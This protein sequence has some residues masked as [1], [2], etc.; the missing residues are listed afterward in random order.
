MAMELPP[1]VATNSANLSHQM[2]T[3]G[4]LWQLPIFVLGVGLLLGVW[5]TRPW[6]YDPEALQLERDLEHARA[7]LSQPNAPA[8]EITLILA[9]ALARGD[10]FPERVGEIHFLL[11]SAYV[12]LAEGLPV[13]QA[14]DLW[15]LARAQ[16]EEAE[17]LV[18]P[19]EDRSVL[20]YRL[21]K[22][23]FYTGVDRQRLIPYVTASIEALPEYRWEA[24]SLL[25]QLYLRPPTDL[26]AALKANERQLQLPIEDDKLLGPVRLLRGELLLRLPDREAARKVLARISSRAAPAVYAQARFLLARSLQEDEAWGEA[27]KLWEELLADN[28]HPIPQ[29]GRVLYC[30]GLCY[31][32][33]DQ[34]R[35]R[36]KAVP[37]LEQASATGGEEGQAAQILL[38]QLFREAGRNTDALARYDRALALVL[39]PAQY[40]NALIGLAPLQAALKLDCEEVHKAGDHETSYRLGKLYVRIAPPFAGHS[41][42]AQMAEARARA[43]LA[44]ADRMINPQAAASQQQGARDQFQEAARAYMTAAGQSANAAEQ[45][46]ALFHAAETLAEAQDHAQAVTVLGQLLSLNP[47]ADKLNEIWYR[48]GE[49]HARLGDDTTAEGYFEKSFSTPGRFKQLAGLHWALL[50]KRK[51]EKHQEG[52]GQGSLERAEQILEQTLQG[53]KPEDGQVYEKALFEMADLLYLRAKWSE[54]ART[55][56]Q[57]LKLHPGSVHALAARFRLAQC[58]QR[59]ADVEFEIQKSRSKIWTDMNSLAVYHK[60]H[61]MNL[62]QAAAHYE[63]V[64]DDLLARRAM[65]PLPPVEAAMLVKALFN[66]A[67][68][69]FDLG[70]YDEAVQIYNRLATDY[71]K[72]VEGLKALQELYRCHM[73]SSPPNLEGA[74]A[75]VSRAR[76]MMETMGDDAF[77][78][79]PNQSREAFERYLKDAEVDLE[80]LRLT[81]KKP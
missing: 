79:F 41:L 1:T 9:D 27:A 2:V 29:P 15:R 64:I 43:T 5:L 31:R 30:L 80:K 47:S 32:R 19:D 76:E 53:L 34:P 73:I 75:S 18:V 28:R 66:K 65:K 10:R 35:V 81:T 67:A 22:A 45:A 26:Q 17:G 70:Q 42:F 20:I 33:S 25:T 8:N 69:R 46:E 21:G 24:L 74:Y 71:Q 49:A 52:V 14:H 57:A 16:L 77:K 54:A 59:L 38:A 12:R 23:W 40:Q 72:Q 55:W 78:G 11:G 13:D 51:V 44:A 50:E 48:L 36:E 7:V 37:I 61:W 62:Q 6:W 56:E 3:F 39:Q 4:Q 68:C 63:K 58:Y 60:R